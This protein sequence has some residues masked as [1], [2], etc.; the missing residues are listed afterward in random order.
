MFRN[1]FSIAAAILVGVGILRL[2]TGGSLPQLLDTDAA[3]RADSK[4]EPVKLTPVMVQDFEKASAPPKVWVVNIPDKNASVQI[5]T[6]HPHEGKQCL[7]LHYHFVGKGEFQYLGIPNKTRIQAPIH[8][9]RFMLHGDDSKCSYGVQVTDASGETHQYGTNTSQ[10]GIIDFKGW[11]EVVIDLDARHETWGGDKNGKLDYPLTGITFIIGQPKEEAKLLPAEGDL[12]FDALS[13]DSEKSA[14]ETLGCQIA[15]TS[16]EYCSSVKGETRVAIAAPGFKT[17]TVKCWKQG[18]GFGSDS[19]VAEVK[20][21]KQGAASFVFAADDYPH[22]PIVVRLSSDNGFAKDN[23]YL[24]LYN[25]GGVSWN[26]GI[27]KDPP[28]AAKDMKLVFADD[29]KGPLSIS[30]TDPK[31]TYYDH[32]PPSGTQ[33][34]SAH[35]FTGFDSPKNPFA[36]VDSYLR[37]RASD[38]THSSGLI[39]SLKNDG[40]GIKV[41]A[42]CYFECRFLGP[43]AIGTWPGFWLMTD[44]LTDYNKLKDKTPCDELDIIEAYGGEGPGSPNAGDTYMITPHCWTQGEAGKAAETEAF[45][46]MHNPIRMKKA[47]IPS[48]WYETFHTYGCKVTETDTIYYCDNIEVGRHATLPLSKKQ[49]L[50]FMVNLAT[51]GGW[52]VDLSRYNGLADMYIDYVRVYREAP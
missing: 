44:Y 48:T 21:D 30:S 34:F 39:S 19:T 28:A 16:P 9:L 38:K 50:F 36:Q 1:K 40:S 17:V 42:P 2:L 7:K 29:F 11:K 49:P 52:P 27:P 45:K 20:L 3:A 25:K 43:N 15:V 10:G 46:A 35:T 6:D 24:Q 8:R 26:E 33:D 18:D 13:V 23:C 22:G 5:S 51:G 47:G 32:K 41:S 31:A 4:A 14:D 12:Y 37:I